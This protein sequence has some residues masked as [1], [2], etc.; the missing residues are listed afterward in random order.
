VFGPS[1]RWA[2]VRKAWW[3]RSSTSSCGSV[4]HLLVE[5]ICC[6]VASGLISLLSPASSRVPQFR[7]RLLVE[8]GSGAVT[9]SMVLDSVF[10]RGKFQRCHVFLSSGPHLPGEVGSGAATWLRSRLPERRALVL[11][12]I[13]WPL[14]G[15]GPQE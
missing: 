13:P 8:V 5:V 4:P 7:S 1:W 6:H 2:P 3:R 15:C 14:A 10:L 9:C 11:P 12:R